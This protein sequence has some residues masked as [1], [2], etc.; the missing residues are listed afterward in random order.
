MYR[1][2][3]LALKKSN[4]II[5]TALFLIIAFLL[6]SFFQEMSMPQLVILPIGIYI[7]LS[8]LIFILLNK[9]FKDKFISKIYLISVFLHFSFL[10]FWHIFK[11]YLLN[12]HLPS[13]NNFTP[14]IIDNDGCLY[15]SLGV[16]IANNFSLEILKEKFTGGLFPKIIGIL[17]H[18]FGHNPFIPCLLNCLISGFTATLFYQIGKIT[19]RNIKNAKI[20]S[21]FSIITFA[22]I[23]NTTVLMRDGYIT[24]FMYLSLFLSYLLYKSKNIIYFLLTLLSCYS[25]YLFRPYAAF[26]IVFAII[27]TYIVL[28]VKIKMN[29]SKL[30]LNKIGLLLVLLSPLIISILIYFLMQI[31]NFMK[32]I[33]VEDLINIREASYAYGAAEVTI[34][35]GSL[36]SKFF[37]L[38]FIIGYIYLFLAP[39]PWEWIYPRR[40][41]YVTD[42]LA[43]YIFLP[44][45][46]RN[47]RYI[48]K[49]KR[50]FV[51]T[52]FFSIVYM[53]SIY[54]ITLGNTGA[55][56]RLRGIFIPMIYLIAM[57]HPNKFLDKI[58][59]LVKKSNVI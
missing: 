3:I 23:M 18:F 14:F 17:Y 12:Y 37:L 49:E 19:L 53:F 59:N 21:L 20:Y 8:V 2:G 29:K 24:I 47:I 36:Y 31:S 10:L 22:H 33:S 54:C 43:L 16:Y 48:F 27:T 5:T 56:H 42:M 45:F 1:S 39:F 7:I 6:F 25:L 55:I 26:V 38:P 44:S 41:V 13:E 52:F 11:Y 32:I 40:M 30:K 58:L 51:V 34:D 57:T 50:Y 4:I 28:N 35:F 46:F 15:H 9:I